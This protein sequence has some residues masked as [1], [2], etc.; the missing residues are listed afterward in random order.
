MSEMYDRQEA[1]ENNSHILEEE[2]DFEVLF[3]EVHI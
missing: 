1:K 3:T 2:K